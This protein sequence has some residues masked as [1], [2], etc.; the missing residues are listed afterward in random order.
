MAVATLTSK[1]QITIPVEVRAALGVGRGA[2][3]SFTVRGDGAV[4]MRVLPTPE[5]D[6]LSL[7]GSLDP[8]GVTLTVEDMN[9]IIRGAG[10]GE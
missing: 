9:E 7:C 3:L 1:G 8:Q 6:L 10:A 4:E 5:V 2:R